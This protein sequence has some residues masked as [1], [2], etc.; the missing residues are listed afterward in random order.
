MYDYKLLE[1]FA[2]VVETGGFEKAADKLCITQS[3]VSQRIKQLEEQSM[4]V[5]LVRSNPPSPTEAGKAFIA[6]Y[7]KV[8]LLESDVEAELHA[9]EGPVSICVG[10]NA[11]TL[12]T[13]FFDAV[14]DTVMKNRIFLNL[15]VDDQ[16]ETHRLLKNGEAAGCVSTRSTP[17]QGCSVTPLMT[18]TYRMFVS[19]EKKREFFPHGFTLDSI[20]EV[21]LIVYNSKDTLHLQ[22]FE[23]VFGTRDIEYHAH[24]VPS[25]EKYLEAVTRGM[26]IGMMPH[27]QCDEP[28][29]LGLIADAA[30]PYKVETR[31]FWHRWNI[32]SKPLDLI[33]KSLVDFCR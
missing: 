15:R 1:A 13:W 30:Y 14:A 9:A 6:H 2:C 21:P 26:G 27:H 29:N 12:A 19:P 23:K 16:E 33:T 4:A 25:V 22:L 17:M 32:R 24:Y 18:T 8:K 5:L 20:K 10:L 31:L 7:N 3:A 28:V 11:D